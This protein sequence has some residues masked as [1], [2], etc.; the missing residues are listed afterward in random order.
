MSLSS[1]TETESLNLDRIAKV[2]SL[3]KSQNSSLDSSPLKDNAQLN[4]LLCLEIDQELLKTLVK[5]SKEYNVNVQAIFIAAF[6]ILLQRYSGQE[7]VL[8]GQ[9]FLQNWQKNKT[10][11]NS[12]DVNV[13]SIWSEL[14]GEKSLPEVLKE[15]YH[16]LSNEAEFANLHITDVKEI[17][18]STQIVE[19]MFQIFFVSEKNTEVNEAS[20]CKSIQNVIDELSHEFKNYYFGLFFKGNGDALKVSIFYNKR[21]F[22]KEFFLRLSGH[23]STLLTAIAENP[24]LSLGSYNILSASE[25]KLLVNDFNDTVEEYPKEKKLFELFEEQAEKTPDQVALI[26][27]KKEITYAELNEQS[28]RLAHYLIHCGVLPG[29][30]VGLL[31]NRDFDMIIGMF[32]ILKAGGAYVPIDPEYPTDRQT[33]IYNQSSLKFIIADGNYPLKSQIAE[34]KFILIDYEALKAFN[35]T[36]PAIKIDSKQLAYTIY[37]SGSTGMPKGV[38]IQHHSAVNLILWVNKK[39]EVGLNDRL[40][41]I[42]SM[43]FDLSVYDIF[44]ILATGGALV[45]A[46]LSEIQNVQI[47]YNMLIEYNITFWDSVPTTMDYL[48]KTL[49]LEDPDYRYAG[50]KTVFMSGDW[51]PVILP[52]R[53]KSFFPKANVVSLGGATEATVWSN[54]FV[55]EQT[56][57]TW[58]SI[59]YG[60]PITNNFFY[61]LNEQLNPV[62]L[63]TVGD[64]YI[65]GVGVAQGY[66]NDT[67]KTNKAFIADPFHKDCGGMMY[68]T[69]DLGRMMPDYNMEFIGRKDNQVKINGFRVELGEIESIL[70]SS[71]LVSNA[72]VLAKN[73]VDGN[74]R[75]VAY[76]VSAG[77]KFDQ[78]RLVSHLKKKLPE[79]M[80]PVVWI[81]LENLPLTSNGKIDRKS[82]PYSN[83]LQATKKDIAEPTTETE[84]TL[85][86]IW[87]EYVRGK[88]LDISS[89]FFEIGGHSL[90]AVQILSKFKKI[91]GKNF[92][93][94]ILYKYPTIK[95]L[96]NFIDHD[97]Q[98]DYKYKSL[99]PIKPSGRK[100]PLYIIHGDG[101][102]VL[103]FS[104]LANHVDKE[105]PIFGL[106]A[107]GLNGIDEP[108]DNLVEIARNYMQEIIRHN[109]A[110]PYLLAGYSSGGYVAMEIRKQMVALGR[111]VKMLIIFD[112]DAEKTEYKD[113]YSLLPKKAK[114]HFPRL[115]QAFKTSIYQS[116]RSKGTAELKQLIPK[117]DSKEFYKLINKIK[118]KHLIAFRNYQLEPFDGKLHLYKAKICVH[119]GE[120]GKFLAWD[121][122][123]KKGVELYE[124]PGDHFSILLPPHV[125]DF[126]STLQRN[127]DALHELAAD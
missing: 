30:N 27:G 80:I 108:I 54:F 18:I 25:R 65:G 106:Q 62:P 124:I 31:V 71:E 3:I 111:D 50:L 126:G 105:Q 4:G 19:E 93:L 22:C 15:I 123:A 38:M 14:D 34:N 110:G 101:M 99:V 7:R 33:Y 119:Y 102:N 85:L 76:V 66:A 64:L 96:A 68:K 53:I 41:F 47:L 73:D 127:L 63:G 1:F 104:Y 107:L 97:Q 10:G 52:E 109:P 115:F 51:I 98:K 67:E 61:I 100:N 13:G 35:K 26:K 28:N 36:N 118:N 95:A 2:N 75:L 8:L 40:L 114:R 92:Q 94:S 83:D 39:F 57:D 12:I 88:E 103:N 11:D 58:M 84:K 56:S 91:S 89:N 49:E 60:R 81:E 78:D 79:Y 46:E 16:I 116:F 24:D 42:T 90:M 37:T 21:L 5:V 74:K 87:K 17:A 29:D 117:S 23:F 45:I 70:N 20:S 6:N 32:G 77:E 72:V 82:L 125:A 59:P 113:W 55:V 44:G 48:V 120:L 86:S 122:Y 9:A 112:T 43:C 121:K 69:G